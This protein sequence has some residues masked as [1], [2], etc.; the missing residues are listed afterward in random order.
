MPRIKARDLHDKA[1]LEDADYR[2]EYEALEER[3][4]SPGAAVL[5]AGESDERVE[6]VETDNRKRRP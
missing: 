3:E 5:E 6:R 1:M 2:R 4:L